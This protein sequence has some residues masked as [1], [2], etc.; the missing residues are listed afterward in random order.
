LCLIRVFAVQKICSFKKYALHFVEAGFAALSY[1][2]RHFGESEGEPRQVYSA[3]KQ[4]DDLLAAEKDN[5]I[6]CAIGNVHPLIIKQMGNGYLN[7][8][9]WAG[10]LIDCSCFMGYRSFKVWAIS[11]DISGNWYTRYNSYAYCTRIC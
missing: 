6:V 8:M 3:L 7:K 10:F 9:V 11:A 4:Y 1:D 5:K 2:Y